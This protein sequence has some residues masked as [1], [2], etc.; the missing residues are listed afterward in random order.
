MMMMMMMIL[1][2]FNFVASLCFLAGGSQKH[3][4]HGRRLRQIPLMD[5]DDLALDLDLDLD[6]DFDEFV[7]ELS[8]SSPPE[9]KRRLSVEQVKFLEA[10]FNTDIKLEPDRKAL[11]ASQLGLRPRQVAIWFQNRRVRWKNKQLERDYDVLKE[12]YEALMKENVAMTK[13]KDTAVAENQ[14]LQAKV[15]LLWHTTFSFLFFS[16]ENQVLYVC[17]W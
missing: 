4:N 3:H 6:L 11:I 9:K 15:K 1:T 12:K 8:S 13:E 2:C 10:S 5:Q 7:D 17:V 16:M 14:K